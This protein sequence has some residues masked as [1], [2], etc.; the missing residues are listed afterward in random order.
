MYL[1]VT[2]KVFCVTQEYMYT[3]FGIVFVALGRKDELLDG[4]VIP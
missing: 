1:N 3:M 4:V 2:F